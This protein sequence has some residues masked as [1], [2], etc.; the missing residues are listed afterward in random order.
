LSSA[1]PQSR[2]TKN[3]RPAGTRRRAPRRA[4]LAGIAL[5]AASPLLL[6]ACG[7][8]PANKVS[9]VARDATPH[10]SG[11]TSSAGADSAVK[12]DR[13]P[14]KPSKDVT[15]APGTAK[16]KTPASASPT[17]SDPS[18]SAAGAPGC[19]AKTPAEWGDAVRSDSFNATT[20]T[21]SGWSVY[22]STTGTLRA[23]SQVKEGDGSLQLIG[24]TIDG[25]SVS[26]GVSDQFAQ[27][28][29]RWEACMKA[30]AGAGYYPAIT[31]WPSGNNWPTDGEIDLIESVDGNRLHNIHFVH[32]NAGN[33]RKGVKFTLDLTSWNL[34]AVDW[35]PNSVVFSVD[36]VKQWTMK[37][38][39]LVPFRSTM[40]MTLQF[41]AQNSPCRDGC[42]NASTPK[43][44]TMYIN[45]MKAFKYD[46]Q[47]D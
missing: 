17:G 20:S 28:Y 43:H 44:P 33:D 31:L 9:V 39:S 26:G 21:P 7:S 1:A 6:T 41:D 14:G 12:S 36:G 45:W 2:R 30:D 37:T 24:T 10:A 25:K 15:V 47:K 42:R 16:A 32:N 29:G 19:S 34:F 18:T 13:H 27:K 4:A 5:V 3:A 35:T 8:T 38:K 23:R 22:S 11:T 40:H 46:D